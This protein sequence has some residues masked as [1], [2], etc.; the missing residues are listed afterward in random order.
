MRITS[1]VACLLVFLNA[2][3]PA[4]LSAAA[5][6]AADPA[7]PG[8][9]ALL[10]TTVS[11]VAKYAQAAEHVAGSVTIVTS[12]D[13]SRFGYRSVS[14][15]L[16]SVAGVYT[17]WAGSYQYIGV[18]GFGRP[19]DYNNRVLLLVDGHTVTESM[20]GQAFLGDELAV[21]LDAVERI[22]IV[23]GPSSALYGTG[24]MFAVVNVI[25]RRAQD[26]G[27]IKASI[28]TGSQ[29]RR[30]LAL[31]GGR[32][33]ENGASLA[34]SGLLDGRDG[35]GYYY[36]EFDDPLTNNGAAEN[37]DWQRRGGAQLCGHYRDWS[38]HGHYSD[39]RRGDPSAAYGMLFNDPAAEVR[40]RNGFLEIGYGA[41]LSEV[42]QIGARAYYDYV[43]YGGYFPYERYV[44]DEAAVDQVA[45]GEVTMR[46]DPAPINRLIA[47]A[48]YRRDL[49]SRYWSPVRGEPTDFNIERSFN[50]SSVYVQDEHQVLEQVS[51]IAG[52][53]H[54][55]SGITGGAT[56][57]RIAA[58]WALGPGTT[59]K[60]TY[61]HGFRAPCIYESEYRVGNR[62][63]PERLRMSE[64]IW[65]QRLGARAK[66][67]T[68]LY[69]YW[70]KGL[71]DVVDM[72]GDSAD[73]QLGY[74][75]RDRVRSQGCEVM[76]D[77]R[78]SQRLRGYLNYSYQSAHEDSDRR[79]QLTN[80]P[81]HL[82]KAG[83][84]AD[85]PAAITAAAEVRY[86]SGR[87]TVYDTET[88][89]FLLANA[90]IGYRPFHGSAV[91]PLRNVELGLRILNL[92]DR[93][94][95]YPG[96]VEHVQPEIPQE[97][98]TLIVRLSTQL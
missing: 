84:A 79:S 9:E 68:S 96:G 90:R 47:G 85:L 15:V 65:M 13:I 24:A 80:S 35:A 56:T 67:T 25:S 81:R 91:G 48:E 30:G 21:N 88:E 40:D 92:F 70:V 14:E 42:H 1:G 51:V 69:D 53:R 63:D 52:I 18:R 58:V 98:R 34:V 6:D 45:G 44:Q 28:E 74:A 89:A 3:A 41:D 49:S 46:W 26:L 17:S 32:G 50:V 62:L 57:P 66:L 94:Y 23:R 77:L 64:V 71:I 60:A 22:E 54:D 37:L 8:L 97:G 43:S 12:E 10:E 31:A 83:W 59:M 16:A 95:A 11:T 61:G 82:A 29:G 78:P 72:V 75:N 86:E 38:L 93:E 7:D 20:W 5:D 87:R 4:G 2:F 36:P 27:G 55:E 19:T 33:F 76:M 39:R 73:A